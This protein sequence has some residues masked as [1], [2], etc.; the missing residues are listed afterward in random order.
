MDE[1][2][3]FRRVLDVIHFLNV[4]A[5]GF[6]ELKTALYR[7]DSVI[8][9]TIRLVLEIPAKLADIFSNKNGS[10]ITTILRK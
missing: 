2:V 10:V 6:L 9:V 5:S 3:C 4:F 8:K 7:P 1:V